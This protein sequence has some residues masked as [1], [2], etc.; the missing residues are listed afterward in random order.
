MRI[1]E[2]GEVDVVVLPS[3]DLGDGV[4]E[5]IPVSLM[6]A[7]SY[8][9]PVISTTTGGIPEL[10]GSEAG[11]LVPERDPLALAEAIEHLARDPSLCRRLGESGRRKVREEFSVEKVVDELIR[12]FQSGRGDA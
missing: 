11:L 1:Y 8:G 10:L 7:M 6:E 9:I 2:K 5:G 4:H 12:R 3:T